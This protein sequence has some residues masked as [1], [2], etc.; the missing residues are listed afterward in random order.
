MR[1]ITPIVI[2]LM[3]VLSSCIDNK[4]TIIENN[5]ND[6]TVIFISRGL[7]G[8]SIRSIRESREYFYACAGKDGLYRVK[9]T[10]LNEQAWIH[11]GLTSDIVIGTDGVCD[12]AIV[13]DS[14]EVICAG[15]GNNDSLHAGLMRSTNQG[16]TWERSDSNLVGDFTGMPEINKIHSAD[17]LAVSPITPGLIFTVNRNNSAVFWSSDAGKHWERTNNPGTNYAS[18]NIIEIEQKRPKRI[19]AAG[20]WSVGRTELQQSTDNGV[21]WKFIPTTPFVFMSNYIGNISFGRIGEIYMSM[22]DQ[23]LYSSD[24]GLFWNEFFT[25]DSTFN[26]GNVI[27]DPN[28]LNHVLILGTILPVTS[29]KSMVF[30]FDNAR[31]NRI[32][33]SNAFMAGQMRVFENNRLLFGT[34]KDG[35]YEGLN[36]LHK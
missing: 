6:T 16:K 8:L 23:I 15:F 3:I 17:F 7:R 1:Q 11:L 26:L 34:Y 20:G 28:D 30:E 32:H 14:D 31:L 19:W 5:A 29:K 13:G 24:D 21:T 2:I 36:I 12:V 25:K 22:R 9:K 27:V 18:M 33:H 10:R 35:V 4:E